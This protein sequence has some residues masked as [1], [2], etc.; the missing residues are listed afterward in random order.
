MHPLESLVSANLLNI[1][2]S[3]ALVGAIG[4]VMFGPNRAL[5]RRGATIVAFELARDEFETERILERWG[6][7]G[8]RAAFW[9]LV[10]D[11]LW[12]VPYVFATGLTCLY[13]QD[14][15]SAKGWVLVARAGTYF[16][17]AALGAG[18]FDVAENTV[19][20]IQLR[21][22]KPSKKGA[23]IARHC[24]LIKFTLI[25]FALAYCAVV[26]GAAWLVNY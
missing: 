16:A 20:L 23:W 24:A 17:W 13:L 25:G 4:L 12:I 6:S 1:K 10:I 5:Q 3:V 19:L 8:K 21:A 22:N 11:Y 9:S 15:A 2:L 7:R 18:V 26:R 14:L